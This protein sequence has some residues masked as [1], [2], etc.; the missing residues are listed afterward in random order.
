LRS[1]VTLKVIITSHIAADKVCFN[2]LLVRS[3]TYAAAMPS[4]SVASV[5][6][7]GVFEHPTYDAY[8]APERHRR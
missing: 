5:F 7:L 4:W 6:G 3:A 2:G 1:A 8:N